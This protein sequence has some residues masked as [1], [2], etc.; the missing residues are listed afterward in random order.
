MYDWQVRNLLNQIN[1]KVDKLMTQDATIA[2]E[3]AAEETSIGAITT[4]LASI[5]AL[6]VSL[7]GE[8]A[9]TPAT[10]A[11]AAQV[12]TDLGTLASTAAAD[13]TADTP[14]PPAAPAP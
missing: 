11:A 5:Q 9:L 10:L 2:A 6:L 14:A 7:Q 13:V 8:T 1:T 12:Q 3:A 4:A